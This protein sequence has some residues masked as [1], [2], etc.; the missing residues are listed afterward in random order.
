MNRTVSTPR[1]F[2]AIFGL[3]CGALIIA[4]AP[5]LVQASQLPEDT[6]A[7]YRTFIGTV[8]FAS[9]AVVAALRQSSMHMRAASEV[10][11]WPRAALWLIVAGV[12]LAID[13]SVWHRSVHRV[14]SGIATILGNTQIFYSTLAAIVLLRERPA[15][16][17]Y[18]AA[19]F[20]F[21]GVVL[22][23]QPEPAVMHT[24]HWPGI[25]YGV[26]TG[27]VYAIFIFI[28]RYVGTVSEL[29]SLYRIFI[30]TTAAAAT[31]FVI[32]WSSDGLLVPSGREL[33]LVVLLGIG[34][35]AGGWFLIT[36]FL[37]RVPL[38]VSGLI[39]LIQPVLATLF[40]WTF[41]GDLLGRLQLA[42]VVL[43]IGAIYVG[44]V[45]RRQGA[46][47]KRALRKAS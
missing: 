32:C 37:P 23:A 28:N 35:H 29:P 22:L 44:T 11:R 21:C 14:G 34:P 1:D 13:F 46:A 9:I 17:F 40:G 19:I 12:I 43:T 24:A 36:T 6:I 45:A 39:L 2:R 25:A 41:F 47:T 10:R 27:I 18:G 15:P 8:I 38:S 5:P 33:L 16:A 20:G 30:P 7:F 42:G 26:L 3:A 31:L 4:A